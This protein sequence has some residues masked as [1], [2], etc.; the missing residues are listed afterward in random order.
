[1]IPHPVSFEEI[2]FNFHVALG[3]WLLSR[4]VNG[5]AH[6]TTQMFASQLEFAEANLVAAQEILSNG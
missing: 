1:M 3:A 5:H 6:P 2:R 4:R